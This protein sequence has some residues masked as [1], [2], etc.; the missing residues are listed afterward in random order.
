[1]PAGI[2]NRYTIYRHCSETFAALNLRSRRCGLACVSSC[3]HRVV[4]PLFGI[5]PA[6]TVSPRQARRKIVALGDSST[7]A[8]QLPTNWA[9]LG[10]AE[11]IDPADIQ[12][13][14]W[15]SCP[16]RIQI[17]SPIPNVL[18]APSMP[19]RRW[20]CCPCPC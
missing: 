8:G 12:D 5:I 13:L 19:A 9:T 1:M 6:E 20:L 2:A 3:P 10:K 15:T 11:V 4:R 16:P 17:L 14:I 7:G 18:T